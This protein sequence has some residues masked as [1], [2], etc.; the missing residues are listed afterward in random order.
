MTTMP[1]LQVRVMEPYFSDHSPLSIQFGRRRGNGG[2]PFRFF[3]CLADDE[4][5]IPLIKNCWCKEAIL[6]N[7]CRVWTKLKKVK[8]ELKALN[9]QHYIGVDKKLKYF[10][11]QLKVVQ[12]KMGTNLMQH[13]LIEEEK[14]LK[15][16]LEKWD[17]VEDS[18]FKQKSRV[19]QL[20]LGDQIQHISLPISRLGI[21]RTT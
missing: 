13:E 3:N 12:E 20:K 8:Q 19:Q 18:I 2:K 5:F 15:S 4:R 21:H 9:T 6:S 11:D 7:M 17:H 1:T 10:R 14:E 16:Q